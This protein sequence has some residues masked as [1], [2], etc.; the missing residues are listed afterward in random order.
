MN[1]DI[2]QF[3]GHAGR[4][5]VE[6]WDGMLQ[7]FRHPRPAPRIAPVSP[8]P[9]ARES[10]VFTFI[11]GWVEFKIPELPNRRF[12][13]GPPSANQNAAMVTLSNAKRNALEKPCLSL[14]HFVLAESS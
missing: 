3:D 8:S 4:W 11:F 2:S 12:L 1:E 14:K 9:L 7:L 5:K 6:V 13:E 10:S